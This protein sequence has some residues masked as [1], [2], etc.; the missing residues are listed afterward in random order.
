MIQ[1][2]AAPVSSPGARAGSPPPETEHK[3][4]P[5]GW[6]K[7]AMFH[8]RLGHRSAAAYRFNQAIA[9]LNRNGP[10]GE[11]LRRLRAEAEMVLGVRDATGRQTV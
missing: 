10:P 9:W 6:F 8:R 3:D 1:H 11:E 2:A 7:L 5:G 4:D